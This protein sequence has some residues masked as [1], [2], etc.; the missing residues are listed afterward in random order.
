MK[1]K[2]LNLT[3]TD[4]KEL[5]HMTKPGYL[6]P[7]LFIGIGAI[8]NLYF[9][10]GRDVQY[11]PIILLSSDIGFATICFVIFY[12]INRK[13][14]KDLK[15]GSKKVKTGK[16]SGKEDRTSF[17]AGSGTLHIPGLGD[18]FPKQWSQKMKPNY[19]VYFIINNYRYKVNK[20]LYD[21]TNIGDLVEMH[22]S[23]FSN[24]LLSIK[25]SRN[26]VYK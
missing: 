12:L 6:I 11:N 10:L 26:N 5:I 14:Y 17:E 1:S 23:E 20:T 25:K 7:I 15:I 22:F 21:K 24:T 16:V 19:L 9:L 13:Y 2:S 8:I 18:R 3:E 4:R